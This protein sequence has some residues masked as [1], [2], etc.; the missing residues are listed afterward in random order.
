MVNGIGSFILAFLLSSAEAVI[1]TKGRRFVVNEGDSVELPCNIQDI[2]DDAVVIWK[3]GEQVL[4]TDEEVFHEDQRFL[5][6]RE[7]NVGSNTTI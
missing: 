4:F 2:A 6:H 1:T 7:N 5:L 3:R